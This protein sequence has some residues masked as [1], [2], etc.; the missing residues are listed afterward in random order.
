MR[1]RRPAL[2][3]N[4]L[5]TLTPKLRRGGQRRPRASA[6]RHQSMTLSWW[7]WWWCGGCRGIPRQIDL[8][9]QRAADVD[10]A[11]QIA[12][13]VVHALQHHVLEKHAL[14]RCV[15]ADPIRPDPTQSD[16]IRYGP[17]IF[18]TIRSDTV[19]PDPARH[20]QGRPDADRLDPMRSDPLQVIGVLL[21]LYH[22]LY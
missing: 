5:Y 22:W 9:G 18:V 11:L 1:A 13:C 21:S 2:N 6:D 19:R 14:L 16:R 7:W 20:G 15:P 10:E 12:V 4:A 8:A 17:I 3:T